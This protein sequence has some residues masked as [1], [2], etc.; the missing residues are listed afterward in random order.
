MF[1]L[2]W[3][4]EPTP[5][6]QAVLAEPF[7]GMDDAHPMH[8]WLRDAG[9]WPQPCYEYTDICMAQWAAQPAIEP[10]RYEPMIAALLHPEPFSTVT[11]PDEYQSFGG[12][13]MHFNLTL[14]RH[15]AATPERY[16]DDLLARMLKANRTWLSSA[17]SLLDKMLATATV[18]A[19]VDAHRYRYRHAGSA[20]LITPL[21]LGEVSLRGAFEGEVRYGAEVDESALVL[22]APYRWLG[23]LAFKPNHTVNLHAA[24]L[25]AAAQWSEDGPCATPLARPAATARL[26][27]KLVNPAGVW[28]MEIGDAAF[29]GYVSNMHRLALQVQVNNAWLDAANRAQ[30]T[31][32]LTCFDARYQADEE[33]L[34]LVRNVEAKDTVLE[35]CAEPF[36]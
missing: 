22:D 4:E 25:F 32:P 21:T 24:N 17:S 20:P 7:I 14:A 19:L 31:S 15:L 27:D 33:R 30:W 5:E 23:N 11:G 26:L 36:A 13:L 12:P 35:V 28:L 3:D 18:G 10:Q 1:S 9:E 29:S 34:C 6:V 16:P 8:V 2:L